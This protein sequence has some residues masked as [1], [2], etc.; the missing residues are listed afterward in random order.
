MTTYTGGASIRD[1][2]KR[3]CKGK[4]ITLAEFAKNAGI[5]PQ[6]LNNRFNRVHVSFDTVNDMLLKN[7][8]RLV[9]DIIP[10]QTEDNST[11]SD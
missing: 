1:A 6:A 2:I 8:L 9:F 10:E 11:L 3:V 7:G 5:A 4:G